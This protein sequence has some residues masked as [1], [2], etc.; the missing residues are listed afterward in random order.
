MEC[1]I[2][3]VLMNGVL[4]WKRYKQKEVIPVNEPKNIA[5]SIYPVNTFCI[6]NIDKIRS[7]Q[8]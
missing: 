7:C 6:S 3:H 2:H 8:L 1:M 5:F 4:I